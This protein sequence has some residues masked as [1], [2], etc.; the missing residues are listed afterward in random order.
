MSK[1]KLTP[2]QKLL[3]LKRRDIVTS[4][5]GRGM[6]QREI[7]AA[8][9]NPNNPASFM[10]NPETGNPYDLMTINRDIHFVLAK[11]ERNIEQSI[12]THK[13]QQEVMILEMYRAAWAKKDLKSVATAIELLMKL[14]GT[15]STKLDLNVKRKP[16]TVEDLSD[17]ELAEIAASL[18][19]RGS[20][21][22]IEAPQSA[23]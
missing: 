7:Q 6:T 23:E 19:T 11:H 10:V 20:T 1:V 17:D 18:E 4:L 15:I 22:A 21:G 14:K 9:A 5:L 3:L 12:E 2:Q 16:I 13:A 8:M